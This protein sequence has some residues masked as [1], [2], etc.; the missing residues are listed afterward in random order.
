MT[1]IEDNMH[2]GVSEPNYTV[3]YTQPRFKGLV[4]TDKDY[5]KVLPILAHGVN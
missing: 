5:R 4:I 1:S 2:F 3:S